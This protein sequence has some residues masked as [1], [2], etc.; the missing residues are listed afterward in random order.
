M[1]INL[2]SISQYPF[3][4]LTLQRLG[5]SICPM[6][7]LLPLE[8]GLMT[9]SRVMA[10]SGRINACVTM[11]FIITPNLQN[12]MA[13]RAVLP[14]HNL[15]KS[16]GKYKFWMTLVSVACQSALMHAPAAWYF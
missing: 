6:D 13:R 8:N 14:D 4:R 7:Q 12:R 15:M 5:R 10:Y 1:N 3:R 16:V 11:N 2:L 9:K